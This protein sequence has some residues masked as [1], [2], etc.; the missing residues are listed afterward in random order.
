M[1]MGTNPLLLLDELRALGPCTVV[2]DTDRDP[3]ARGA[4]PDRMPH[5]LG[6]DADHRPAAL[7]DRAGL[8]VRARRHAARAGTGIGSPAGTDRRCTGG[9]QTVAPADGKSAASPDARPAAT[10]HPDVPPRIAGSI[11]VPAE[12]LDELMDRVGELVIA[13]S[14]LKQIAAASTRR[15]GEG[16]RRGDRA[17]GAGTARHHDG[18]AHG[19]DRPVVRPLPPA[20]ARPGARVRQADRR[21]SPSARRPS[22]TRR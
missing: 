10:P 5:R 15:A 16:G 7:G 6:G 3:A 13:Q 11:R 4:E 18:R 8:P 20:G 22:S 1:A 17:A 21:W 9:G 19:A 14:R 2:A 12:R